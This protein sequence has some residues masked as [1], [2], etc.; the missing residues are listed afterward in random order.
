MT[1]EERL[2]TLELVAT[3]CRADLLAYKAQFNYGDKLTR[4]QQDQLNYLIVALER[5][6]H[7]VESARARFLG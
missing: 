6:N 1:T 7:N 4:A 2:Y 3:Q 5:A